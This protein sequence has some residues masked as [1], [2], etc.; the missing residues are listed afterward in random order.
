MVEA[1]SPATE[2]R[3]QIRARIKERFLTTFETI[4]N[5]EM[6]TEEEKGNIQV[7]Q[8]WDEATNVMMAFGEQKVIEGFTPDDFRPFFENW[9]TLG[10]DA[11]ATLESVTKVGSDNGVDTMKVVASCP[12][13]L[14]NR[15]MFSTRYLELDQ[16]G[17]HMMLFC[18]DGNQQYMEDENIFTAKEKKNL[19]VATVHCSGWW[20]KPAKNDAG[21]TI[22]THMLYF[23][24][25]DA[26]GNIPTFVQNSQGPKTALNSIKGTVAWAKANKGK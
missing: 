26:G 2:S 16:D 23:S 17:G 12:W 7:R 10:C 13:P 8:S 25:I 11:N 24:Q 4:E 15:V 20:V 14:S 18:T 9:D 21:E 5:H 19:V 3:D 1:A 6:K 22:G